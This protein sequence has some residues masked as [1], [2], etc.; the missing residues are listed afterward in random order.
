MIP[1][2]RP[3]P[4]RTGQSILVVDDDRRVVELLE[5][6]LGSHGY[7]VVS[8]A[9]G[10]EA[11]RVALREQ[12][13]LVVLDVRLPRRSG[14]EVCELLRQDPE[15]RRVPIILISAMGETEVRV[16]GLG[17][18]ADDF[19]SK[20][21]SPKEL[22]ARIRRLLQR[23]EE[24]RQLRQRSRDLENEL[25]RALDEARRAT[26]ELRRERK[27]KEAYL[28]LGRELHGDLDPD[29]VAHR[30][31]QAT[32]SRVGPGAAALLLPER[33]EGGWRVAHASGA[34]AARLEGL[35]LPLD[36]ELVPIVGGLG[37]PL[38]AAELDRFAELGEE[39]RTLVACG[40]ALLAP[41]LSPR[42]FEG[43]LVTDEK[44][45]G[46]EYSR[47]DM[48]TLAVL[49]EA[50]GVALHG[51]SQL[52]EAQDAW[53]GLTAGLVAAHES[54]H[55]RGGHTARVVR[56]CEGLAGELDFSWSERLLLRRAAW[57]HDLGAA[58]EGEGS[59]DAARR[60]TQADRAGA[61]LAMVPG[62]EAVGAI[63]AAEDF[64]AEP[65]RRRRLALALRAAHRWEELRSAGASPEQARDRLLEAARGA[66][67][68]ASE[69]EVVEA[70]IRV[71]ERLGD[72]LVAA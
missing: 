34:G 70:L 50:A 60:E 41:L 11:L 39:C 68:P 54:R 8:A 22:V 9:N 19:L 36:S 28:S 37:R 67:P 15:D 31:L 66:N 59:A 26:Q 23:S 52:T 32:L 24:E 72:D 1:G 64:M 46:T 35:R 65:G 16:D 63:V 49:C 45:S 42:G 21:F 29:A 61:Y 44:A 43:L 14:L 3:A 51:A 38:R 48:D 7:R 13:D 47:Q 56:L 71:I 6:A 40:A 58:L 10:E 5:V 17:R 62:L 12:P 2:S 57:L 25:G 53:L 69:A 4:P 33:G 30:L 55:G 18:G 27:V 20:P